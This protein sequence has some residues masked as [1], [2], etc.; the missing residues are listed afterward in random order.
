VLSWSRSRK[1][2]RVGAS[3][4]QQQDRGRLAVPAADR[5]RAG[6]AGRPTHAACSDRQARGRAGRGIRHRLLDGRARR[7]AGAIVRG[8]AAARPGRARVRSRRSGRSG[9]R[10]AGHDHRAG[11]P[12]GGQTVAARAHAAR[13]GSPS[14]RPRVKPR[15]RRTGVW[16][17]AG[18]AAPWADRDADGLVAGQALLGLSVSH[19]P[20]PRCGPPRRSSSRQPGPASC[21]I[22]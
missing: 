3:G 18:S 6:R 1:G 7:G 22:C 14:L 12:P 11:R 15:H 10:G 8:A 21:A 2:G 13:A 4:T 19:R 9:P 16:G 20:R 17:V 5:A